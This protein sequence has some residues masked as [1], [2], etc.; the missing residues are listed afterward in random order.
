MCQSEVHVS[1]GPQSF[2]ADNCVMRVSSPQ[3]HNTQNNENQRWTLGRGSW[4]HKNVKVRVSSNQ[5]W[6]DIWSWSLLVN[7]PWRPSDDTRHERCID[8]CMDAFVPKHKSLKIGTRR[9]VYTTD[10]KS[11]TWKL[12]RLYTVHFQFPLMCNICILRALTSV[13]NQEPSSLPQTL[14]SWTGTLN[15]YT[16]LNKTQYAIPV[17][18]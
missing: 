8:V 15:L 2:T 18:A 11:S 14:W 12:Q 4:S 17:Y 10:R 3:D 5:R 13:S 6:S 1:A 7:C 9:K 16:N